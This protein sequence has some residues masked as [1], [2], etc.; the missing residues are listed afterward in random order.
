MRQRAF[1]LVELLVVLVVLSICAVVVLPKF[2]SAQSRRMTRSVQRLTNTARAA[3]NLAISSQGYCTLHLNLSE[4]HYWLTLASTEGTEQPLSEGLGAS[5]HL[6]EGIRFDQVEID[7]ALCRSGREASFL[8][9]PEGPCNTGMIALAVDGEP[10]PWVHLVLNTC[11]M[12][13]GPFD[14]QWGQSHDG[15]H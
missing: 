1:T 6:G 7:D 5:Q 4:G 10:E 13:V 9:G 2:P 12:G 14:I 15:L 8:F 11:Q 3:Q